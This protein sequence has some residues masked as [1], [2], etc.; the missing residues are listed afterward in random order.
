MIALL[1]AL[2]FA[3][4]PADTT[5]RA[6]LPPVPVEPER[7][8]DEPGDCPVMQ[9]APAGAQRDCAAVSVPPSYL[10]HLQATRVH[11]DALRFRL[12]VIESTHEVERDAWQHHIAFRDAEIARLREP[13]PFL[14]KP[15]TQVLGGTLV[16]VAIT[17]AA[18]W[19]LGQAAQ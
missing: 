14:Q 7:P 6:T 8:P 3:E 13:V 19:A 11:A 9:K 17:A 12:A 5:A 1:L 15:G 16:G 10:A 4:E 18:G 2:A